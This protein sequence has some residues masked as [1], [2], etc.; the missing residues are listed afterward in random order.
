MRSPARTFISL[1]AWIW[2]GAPVESSLAALAPRD[3][4][5]LLLGNLHLTLNQ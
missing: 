5:D 3:L 1:S 2:R 4:N